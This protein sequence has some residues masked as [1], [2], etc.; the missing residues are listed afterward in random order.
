MNPIT[1]LA[2]TTG[3]WAIAEAGNIMQ[4]PIGYIVAFSVGLSILWVVIAVVKKFF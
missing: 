4:G 2:N 3:S 1:E